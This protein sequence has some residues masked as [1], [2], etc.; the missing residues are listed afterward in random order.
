MKNFTK[1][2]LMIVSLILFSN[3]VVA[4]GEDCSDPIVINGG[5]DLLD[6]SYTGVWQTTG[7]VNDYPNTCM[8]NYDT[9]ADV[10]YTFVLSST[11]NV[12]LTLDPQGATHTGIA[13]YDQCP[14]S[15]IGCID[16]QRNTNADIR[17]I[18][19]TDLVAGTY[20]VLISSRIPETP[21]FSYVVDVTADVPT[22]AT[23]PSP[24]DMATNIAPPQVALGW[25]QGTS[26]QEMQIMFGTEYP[27]TEI[28]VDWTS[29][30][31]TTYLADI[32]YNLQ[33]FWQINYRNGEGT[34]MGDVWGFTAEIQPPGNLTATAFDGDA[35]GVDNDVRV[36][37]ETSIVTPANRA[38]IGYNI[39]ENGV[40]IATEVPGD[41]YIVYDAPYNMT[42]PGNE[43][44]AVAVFD[45]G[46][47]AVSNS[48]FALVNGLGTFDGYAYDNVS[49][50]P[51]AGATIDITGLD[52]DSKPWTYQATTDGTGYYEIDVVAGTYDFTASQWQYF[53]GTATGVVVGFGAT[54]SQDLYLDPW[55]PPACATDPYPADGEQEINANNTI[56]SWTF[57]PIGAT[58]EYQLLFDTEYPPTG[59][60][61][62]WTDVLEEEFA[63]PAL[64][65]NMQYFW[66]VQVRNMWGEVT[67]CDIWGFTT[68]I[69]VPGDLTATVMD[70][71][72]VLLEWESS[73]SDR[74]FIEYVVYR[75]AAEIAR[76][77]DIEYLD[78]DLAY[79]PTTCYSYQVEAIFDEGT[80]DMSNTAEACITG[81]GMVD[82]YVMDALTSDPI[83]GATV[84]L[85]GMGELGD[86]FTYTFTTDVD[87][88]YYGDVMVGNYDYEVTADDYLPA[89]LNDDV[90][91]AA[92][93]TNDFYLNEYPYPLDYVIATELNDD[94]AHLEWGFDMAAFVPT[95]FPFD[96][97]GMSDAQ[98]QKHMI[99]FL[100]SVGN[101]NA[102]EFTM[103]AEAAEGN[104]DIMSFNVYR[105]LWDDD[106]MD[107]TYIGNTTQMQ[108]IDYDWGAQPSGVYKWAVEIV[109]TINNSEPTFSNYLDKDMETLVHIE[110]TLNSAESPAGTMVTLVNTSETYMDPPLEYNVV[111]DA[112]GMATIDPFRKGD[113]DIEVSLNGYGPVTD[114]QA[115][116][117]ETTLE[118]LL[119]ELIAPPSDLYVNPNGFATWTGEVIPYMEYLAENFDAGMPADWTVIDGGSN[120]VTWMPRSTGVD[121]TPCV[122]ANSDAAGSGSQ[123]DEILVTPVIDPFG[124]ETLFIEFDQH[125]NYGGYSLPDQGMVDVFDGSAW[126]TVWTSPASDL[127][128]FNNPNHVVLDVSMYAN[129]DFQVRFHY[130]SLGW[131]WYWRIDNVV[132]HNNG[133]QAPRSLNSYKV[134]LDDVLS[135]EPTEEMWDYE[136]NE[137]LVEGQTYYAEVASVF[138]T[139]ISDRVGYMF[140]YYPCTYFDGPTSVNADV[141]IG[142]MDAL[143]TW[144]AVASNVPGDDVVGVNIFRDGVLIDMVPVGTNFY[145][146]EQLDAADYEYCITNVYESEAQSCQVCDM[147]TITPGGYVN[148]YVTEFATGDPIEGATVALNGSTDSYV[149]TTDEDGYY[150]GEVVAGTYDYTASAAT[151]QSE[152]LEDVFIDFGVTVS[153]DF[154]LKE[155]P[156]PVGEVI[157]TELNDNSVLVN[158]SGQSTGTSE[159]LIY[160]ADVLGFDGIGA[161]TAAYSLIWGSKWVPA[162]LTEYGTGYVTK[163]AV[164][165]SQPIV[166]IVTEVR[167]MSGDGTNILY[168][169]DI[170][171][172]TVTGQWNIIELDE[173]VE[174]DNTENL[175]IGM[176][177]ERPAGG[178]V[179]EPTSDVLAVIADR[180]DY[181]AYNGADWTSI[182]GEYGIVDQAWMLR[183]FVSTT[184]GGKEVALGQGD[185]NTTGHKDYS[186]APSIP[187]G[188]GM[189]ASTTPN[190][191][192]PINVNG[193]ERE[194]V[195]Y[196][197]YVGPCG[198][199][200]GDMTFIG[201]TLDQTFTDNTWAVAEPGIYQWAV[202]TVYDFNSSAL[203]F[204]NCLDKD[205]ETMV[206]VE[207]S[208]NSGDS[209]EGTDVVF[210]NVS[211]ITDPPIVFETELDASGI[212]TWEEFRKGTYDIYVHLN[213]FADIMVEDVYIWDEAYFEFMLEEL[214]APPSD[215]YVTPMGYATWTPGG[216]VP[217][218]PFLETFDEGIPDTWTIIDGG[219]TTDTW[220]ME[221]PAGNPQ[222]PGSSLD[223]TP[224]AYADSDEAGSGTTMDEL[225][226][227]PVIEYTEN[228]DALFVEFD[229]IYINLSTDWFA[230]DV[231]DGDDWVEVFYSQED[232]GPFPWP[233]TSHEMIDV[234]EYANPDFQ[235]RF[236]YVAPGWDWYVAIDNVAVTEGDSKYA[237]RMLEYYKVW[238]DFTFITDRDTTFYQYGDNGEVLVPGETYMA[239]VAAVY[240]TG[241]SGKSFYEWTYY[242]C[243]SFPGPVQFFAENIEDTKDVLLT[244]SAS[245]PPFNGVFED[246]EDG[247]PAEF[248]T[249]GDR[250]SVYDGNL[251]MDG[252]SVNTY[253]SAY[254]DMMFDDFVFEFEINREESTGTIGNTL[255]CLVRSD[256]LHGTGTQ[257]G[258]A[259]ALTQSGSWWYAKYIDGVLSDWTGWLTSTAIN[260]GLG[261]S[262]IV[263]IVANGPSLEYYVNGTMI[264]SITDADYTEGYCTVFAY[265]GSAGTNKVNFDY[266]SIV[267]GEDAKAVTTID[268]VQIPGTGTV[269]QCT[270]PSVASL[271]LPAT[272]VRA[273]LDR[274]DTVVGAN[275]YR[276]GEMI[277]FVEVP[278]TSYVDMDLMPGYYDYCISFLYESGAYSCL[279]AMCVEEV[280]VPE[281]CDAPVNLI[282][283]LD[284]ETY[285]TIFL[286]WDGMQEV[287][288]T[289]NPGAPANGYFQSYDYGYGV[290][291][292]LSAYPDALAHSIEFHHASWG[293]FGPF[294]YNIHIINWDTE[295]TIAVLGPFITTG[296][297]IWEMGVDLED[298][299]LEGAE[300]VGFLMEPLSNS[301][302]D[303]YPDLSSD[304][305]ANPQGSVYGPLADVGSIGASTIGNFLMN[306]YIMT[307]FGEKVMPPTAMISPTAMYAAPRIGEGNPVNETTITQTATLAGSSREWLGYNIYRDGDL[308]EELWPTNTYADS[309][310]LEAG[311][312]YCY[313]ITSMYSI[314]G[315]SPASN[316]ACAGFVG[317]PELDAGVAKLYPNPARDQI[318]IE[319][320]D[321]TRLHIVN[322]VGQV[323]Y[324]AEF[325]NTQSRNLNTANYQSGVYVARIY[326]EA[327]VITKRFVVNR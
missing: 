297:D 242:P 120:A 118:Y 196:N 264:H 212:Y 290:V 99:D 288:I 291:Y 188:K 272:G 38:L 127:G 115:I 248:I 101:A 76:T 102:S 261:N 305:A 29:S 181:F 30:L 70:V 316:E 98:I 32:D 89:M 46:V 8:G 238:H 229:Y 133:V 3:F 167:V 318:T 63:L 262:N 145:L 267:P 160:D 1:M 164:Y 312:L 276:D 91:Y 138:T 61:V 77:T 302:T 203:V 217:F 71:D 2:F 185:F 104:R 87:G 51:I 274:Q 230:V 122:E 15:S 266:Y 155:F 308:I 174:F 97:D 106:F 113:Y 6:G 147:V 325:D 109:Y 306:I 239:E 107:M 193:S 105:G 49:M 7:Y 301:P 144:T 36:E 28:A 52:P 93:T 198:G 205:M 309:E 286:E 293:V 22:M 141:V 208:T 179:N 9:G 190:K 129:E 304:N 31:V 85:D 259:F 279:D 19:A 233:P 215:L 159:W 158:W 60:A 231:F 187:S 78:E 69:T 327:G 247:M 73:E 192:F 200:E 189:I 176:Y 74:A 326:T 146:D 263:S 34:T 280:L 277:A 214:L 136:A 234:T 197:V 80:S 37:W 194:I 65:P 81:M 67:D 48:D 195:G 245:P 209:P 269:D 186:N 153:Q 226:I 135:G 25:D 4:Q 108:F 299:D 33:Y 251:T 169:Q 268:D 143:V 130:L 310:G 64:E 40:M 201:F 13:L 126:V 10:I 257:N 213:G 320:A 72:D 21:S 321:M 148:G 11:A 281:D 237:D 45:E 66:Q 191:Q 219:S 53:D 178:S 235:V 255:G 275:L 283:T 59:V 43:Y 5:T 271:G 295:E 18:Y 232:S 114:M 273:M 236:H 289:Q 317:V 252:N 121:G 311:N 134:W 62:A 163:V 83:E 170:T 125:W 294:D 58:V 287:F 180:Y 16:N 128:G 96:T 173:A 315:E 165:Q 204:S 116:Y 254:Y 132:V 324:D 227:S 23:N 79:N 253:G 86:P 41:T 250:W 20:Y 182:S 54:V 314:C 157:A 177:V 162:Q 300:N 218:E 100:T 207:V 111:L 199:D 12:T 175:W 285:D 168:S 57:D 221:T 90:A 171:G 137:P 322:Y 278:D 124:S 260:S 131:N 14:T 246:F 27:P 223:G 298:I 56:A 42:A 225:L 92:T 123:S 323:V 140:T 256:G 240:S 296:D 75:D 110:V 152:M 184:P 149:F 84:A 244:W 156:Y 82:G 228:A 161:E 206:T 172:E 26:V 224:F 117:D 282:A 216:V 258:Y 220:Y 55:G 249:D 307:A 222:S 202:E 151:Y 139:G 112:T 210:T 292:D 35:G 103:D 24:V 119:Y 319:A 241:I 211:E 94:E 150:E 183:G 284:E 265:D 313:E 154:M 166:D 142:T 303:A 50:D 95:Y 270:T 39:Y 88:Y 17:T 243:D 44:W 68:T 47:S